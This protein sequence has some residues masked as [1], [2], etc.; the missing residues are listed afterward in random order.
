MVGRCCWQGTLELR[1]NGK[2]T[3]TRQNGLWHGTTGT[4]SCVSI[5]ARKWKDLGRQ[6]MGKIEIV[7]WLTAGRMRLF[8]SLPSAISFCAYL[9]MQCHFSAWRYT[10][11]W[12]VEPSSGV[13]NR[14]MVRSRS[15]SEQRQCD[16]SQL[17]G[18]PVIICNTRHVLTILRT[19]N[20][21]ELEAPIT[22]EEHSL[23]GTKLAA[24]PRESQGVARGELI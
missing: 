8:C 2:Q 15:S 10:P 24:K 5:S 6:G 9:L 21:R 13:S 18:L 1:Q 11:I 16:H 23:L 3:V 22:I 17:V 7:D 20:A 4:C 12:R 19:N 14:N